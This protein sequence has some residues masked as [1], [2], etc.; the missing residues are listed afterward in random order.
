MT[1][2][3]IIKEVFN[4]APES[5]TDETELMSFGQWDSMTHMFFITQVEESF[6]IE[7]SGDQI[8]SM[9]TVGEVRS[10]VNGQS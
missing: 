8:A 5:Y 2:E 7:L 4:E 3:D 6:G 9:K 10:I 1:L